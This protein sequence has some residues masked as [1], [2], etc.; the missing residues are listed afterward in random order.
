[1][2]DRVENRL[3]R[4]PPAWISRKVGSTG[5]LGN[6]E[7]VRKMMGEPIPRRADPRTLDP[8]IASMFAGNGVLER[9]AKKLKHISKK[10]HK[11]IIPAHNTVCCVDDEEN[12]YVGVEFLAKHGDDEDL[13]AG[14]FAHEW[15]HMISDVP[16]GKNWNSLTWEEIF[17]M[18]RDEEAYAD[19]YAGRAL[20][21]LGYKPESM[22]EF[23]K[24]LEKKR[25][26]KFPT[27]KY[28][29]TATR[30]AILQASFEAQERAFETAERIFLDPSAN[31]T[32]KPKKFIGQG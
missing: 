9:I 25:N 21:L 4:M 26:P 6:S 31:F 5:N 7:E 22:M 20:Y 32:I 8:R 28:H 23:L 14:I 1:M 3:L 27:F 19:G 11:K 10:K 17:A 15:G 2:V 12:I 16:R 30:V 29:N 24:L 18:R 13:L